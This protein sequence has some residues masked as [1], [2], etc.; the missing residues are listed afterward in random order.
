MPSYARLKLRPATPTQT[1]SIPTSSH[2]GLIGRLEVRKGTLKM[3]EFL[4]S[5]EMF[6]PNIGQRVRFHF[7]GA[8]TTEWNG[9]PLEDLAREQ[10]WK[11]GYS[12]DVKFHGK[13]DQAKLPA[14]LDRLDG[15]VYPS[16]FENYP[17]ALLEVMQ[18]RQA[19]AGVYTRLHAVFVGDLSLC[20]DVRSAR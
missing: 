20:A 12:N 18:P 4:R 16:L 11:D 7:M 17:N 3:L 13:I 1:F 15:V 19:G 14:Y 2:I 9:R 6:E 8:S 5:P 10:I